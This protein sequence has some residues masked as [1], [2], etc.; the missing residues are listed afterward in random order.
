MPLMSLLLFAFAALTHPQPAATVPVPPPE[1]LQPTSI[2]EREDDFLALW[3]HRWDYL[4]AEN[5]APGE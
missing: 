5:P 2:Q 4:W 3:P 1:P